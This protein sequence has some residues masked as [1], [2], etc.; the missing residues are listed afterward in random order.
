VARTSPV[1]PGPQTGTQVP[2]EGESRGQAPESALATEGR[3]RQWGASMGA[4]MPR[5]DHSPRVQEAEGV[6]ANPASQAGAHVVPLGAPAVQS[7][8]PALRRVGRPGQGR[9]E[10]VP[11]V[12]HSALRQEA[13]RVPEAPELHSGMHVV[14]L[15][16]LPV[17]QDPGPASGMTGG[18][19]QGF[20]EHV[21]V[22]IHAVSW[23]VATIVPS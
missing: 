12:V 20:S 15:G 17:G 16:A 19:G 18:R 1:Y 11:V 3:E 5:T 10:Q 8:A 22:T 13:E 4:H 14:P 2:P 23:H 9:G 7:P 6:P 21:P